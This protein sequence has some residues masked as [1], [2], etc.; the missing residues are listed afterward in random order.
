MRAKN[1]DASEATNKTLDVKRF[2]NTRQN[3]RFSN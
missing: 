1:I 2:I 3:N